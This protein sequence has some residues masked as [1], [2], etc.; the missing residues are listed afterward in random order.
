VKGLGVR[1]GVTLIVGGGFHG[2]STVL[3]GLEAGVYNKVPGDGREFVVA[4]PS[5]VKV[6]AEDGRACMAVDIRPFINNLPYGKDTASF[7]TGNASGSTSQAANILEAVEVGA[8]TLLID[9]D[10]CATNFMIRDERMQRLVSKDKEPITPFIYKV[11][12]LYTDCG[13]SSI[14]VV[15]GSGDYFDVADHV[16]MMEGYRP[17][18]V[19]AEA[20]AIAAEMPSGRKAEGGES[21]GAITPRFPLRPSLAVVRNSKVKVR[22]HETVAIGDEHTLDLSG[23][24]QLVEPSQTRAIMDAIVYTEKQDLCSKHGSLKAIVQAIDEVLS[25]EGLDALSGFHLGTYARPRPAEIAAAF[26]RLRTT[27]FQQSAR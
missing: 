7:S 8:T 16:I 12:Q 4:E 21:F 27:Q 15:G 9:E 23:V 17:A 14:M 13:V 22:D 19:T 2:K 5:S 25:R 3:Q 6:R 11:R 18:H 10:T 26:N 24:E 20:K 1:Q